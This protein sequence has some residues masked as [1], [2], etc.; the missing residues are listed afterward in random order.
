MIGTNQILTDFNLGPE[1]IYDDMAVRTKID[2][3][4]R[5]FHLVMFVEHFEVKMKAIVKMI[6]FTIIGIIDTDEGDVL[7]DI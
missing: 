6:R 7:L 5:V 2:E 3:V 1:D 4:E